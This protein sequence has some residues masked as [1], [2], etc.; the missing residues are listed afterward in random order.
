MRRRIII[1]L[2]AEAP[3]FGRE[4]TA[5]SPRQL[6]SRSR[7]LQRLSRYVAIDES[8]T[9]FRVSLHRHDVARLDERTAQGLPHLNDAIRGEVDEEALDELAYSASDTEDD[10]DGVYVDLPM[11]PTPGVCPTVAVGD[12]SNVEARLAVAELQALNMNGNNVL[13]VVVDA[14][15]SATYLRQMGRTNS[16]AKGW[17][18]P[19]GVDPNTMPVTHGTMTAFDISIAAPQATLWDFPIITAAPA[20]EA[21]ARYTSDGAM[22]FRW[23][24]TTIQQQSLLTQFKAI[25]VN[26]SWAIY[27]I[28]VDAPPGHPANYSSNP[29]HTFN[30]A[31]SE[32]AAAGVDIVFAAGNC[33]PDC[34]S[35]ACSNAGATIYGANSHPDVLC[36]GAVTVNGDMLGYSSTGP[37][38][39]SRIKP[40]LCAFSHFNGSR[41]GGQ[42]DI[43]TSASAPVAA[44]IVAAIRGRV[45]LNATNPSTLPAA[46]RSF[47]Q[48]TAL[49]G[50]AKNNWPRPDLGWGILNG[51][52]I[53]THFAGSV[54]GF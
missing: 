6:A 14:G 40:D 42:P 18:Y 3:D 23:L 37:G 8:F 35:T 21:L 16:V 29:K 19:S 34:P 12:L 50:D 27:D 51:P 38:F 24:V 7:H 10:L 39:L 32:L 9:P 49:R 41:V 17:G 28:S 4:L 43:G 15:I 2:R 26:N 47:L 1:E 48:Q 22:A 5:H 36:V 54:G 25:I 13:V 52:A 31:V 20:N 46:L 53:A 30:S 45:P 11:L 33:G 44:G